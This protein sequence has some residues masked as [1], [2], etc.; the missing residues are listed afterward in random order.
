LSAF[1][2]PSG[3]VS[4]HA[5]NAALLRPQ[6]K[7]EYFITPKFTFRM[8]AAYV[9]MRPDIT[10]TTPA[11]PIADRWNASHVHANIGFGVYPFRK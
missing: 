6:I 11:G 3:T 9:L 1:D 8:S 7:A 5:A 4:V 10:V 2:V